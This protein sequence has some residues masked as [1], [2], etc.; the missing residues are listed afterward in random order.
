MS[1]V[2]N[3]KVCNKSSGCPC[4][5]ACPNDAWYWDE[6]NKRPTVDNSKCTNCGICTKTCP[7]RV[8]SGALDQAGV[9]KIN[10][11]IEADERTPN[12]IFMER[13]NVEPETQ[14]IVVDSN[15]FEDEVLNAEGVVI[16]DFW[17][18]K[19]SARCKNSTMLY[20][21]LAPKT[22]VVFKK[23]DVFSNQ[24]FCK[25]IRITAIPAL[26]VYYKGKVI[27]YIAGQI[28][29]PEKDQIKSRIAKA[30]ESL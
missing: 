5:T 23:L 12:Q 24:D 9:E 30:V 20:T 17:T 2:I 1:I 18:P 10:Q 15:T 27:D 14:D 13:F 22:K 25:K 7:A 19:F 26:V 16:V 4:I 29:W 8:I 28:G 3:Y 21:E 11:E 6:E